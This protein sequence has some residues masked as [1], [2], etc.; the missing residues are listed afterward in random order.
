MGNQ[1]LR[2]ITDNEEKEEMNGHRLKLQ[3]TNT[4]LVWLIVIGLT[5]CGYTTRSFIA[6]KYKTIYVAQFSNQIDITRETDASRRY[7]TY[8][9]RLETDITR[10]VIDRFMFDG[11]LRIVKE[12][13]A[14][15]ILNGALIDFRRDVLRYTD[16]DE[17]VEEYR[18]S[19]T[20]NLSL[21]DNNRE[22]IWEEQNFIGDTTYFVSGA[23]AK[24]ESAAI[25]DAIEDLSRRIIERVV[26]EW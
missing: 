16:D 5:G 22:L 21:L 18:I 2:K 17:E 24:S 8:R 10:E 9:P 15:L 4:I 1:I 3:I 6:T 14:D 12:D 23:N 20:V 11:N 25:E 13:D 26:E 19:L 7:K